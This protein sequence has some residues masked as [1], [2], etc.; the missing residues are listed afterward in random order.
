MQHKNVKTFPNYDLSNV[1]YH[2]QTQSGA[3]TPFTNLPTLLVKNKY[4]LASVEKHGLWA[5]V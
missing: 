3:T 1:L 2:R 4:V 5:R